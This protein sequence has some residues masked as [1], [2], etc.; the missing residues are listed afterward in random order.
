VAEAACPFCSE[1]LSRAELVRAIV[2]GTTVRLTR[3]AAFVFGATLAVSAVDCGGDTD[4]Q[5]G[6]ADDGSTS[7]GGDGV[8]GGD[9]TGGTSDGGAAQPL[10]GDPGPRPDAG[11]DAPDDDGG[12]Q[13]EYGAPAPRDGG[14]MEDDGGAQPLYGAPASD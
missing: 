4:N 5:T 7:G 12:D 13:A 6:S 3:A 10:Y 9:G 2:P 8:G 1:S 14:M 11:I